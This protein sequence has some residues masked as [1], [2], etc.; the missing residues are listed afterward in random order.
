MDADA[1]VKMKDVLI[2]AFPF[3]VGGLES[4]VVLVV[5]AQVRLSFAATAMVAGF[6]AFAI[7]ILSG[8][9][10]H[11][12][13]G[14]E[15]G[16]AET[17][18]SASDL[19]EICLMLLSWLCLKGSSKD[20]DSSQ[21]RFRSF[22]AH[23]SNATKSKDALKNPKAIPRPAMLAINPNS[24]APM[25]TAPKAARLRTEV[26]VPGR[27]SSF[28]FLRY[29]VISCVEINPQQMPESND[30]MIAICHN[31]KNAIAQKDITRTSNGIRN[32]NGPFL[33][34]HVAA[35]P[36]VVP[37]EKARSRLLSIASPPLILCAQG[38]VARPLNR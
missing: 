20:Y 23:M 34:R 3:L 5:E 37:I 33:Y 13:R 32:V 10:L 2:A 28:V 15:E 6:V 38:Y 18:R 14:N 25:E 31:E 16:A 19:S 29:S 11:S 36:A 30:K 17:W 7:V 35:D 1:F 9:G 27:F 26:T 8:V 4:A 12:C 21:L 22:A 24:K